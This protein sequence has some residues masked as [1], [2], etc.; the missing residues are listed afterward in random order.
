MA[1]PRLIPPKAVAG[2][3]GGVLIL[4][5]TLHVSYDLL[6]RS[7]EV[8][9]SQAVSVNPESSDA[10]RNLGDLYRGQGRTE[11]ARKA[12]QSAVLS[13][14]SNIEARTALAVQLATE[15]QFDQ[16]EGLLQE[17]LGF[18]PCHCPAL[19]NLAMVKVRRG[20]FDRAVELYD[21]SL[22][23]DPQNGMAHLGLGHIYFGPLKSRPKA[24]EHYQ[25]FLDIV[26][27]LHPAAGP[28]KQRLM[29]LT[30]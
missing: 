25:K 26:D 30:W 2:L 24:A 5:G 9:W 6:W 22:G 1:L 19:N 18:A 20:D 28:T 7:E 23:C 12:Y 27:P 11:D 13:R 8:L 16:A 17:S 3:L 4:Y 21:R 29:E 15:G 10:W 14:P